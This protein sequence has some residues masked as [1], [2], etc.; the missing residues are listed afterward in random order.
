M[1]GLRGGEVSYR[2]M[3]LFELAVFESMGVFELGPVVVD[4]GMRI[5][6]F[7]DGEP[8]TLSQVSVNAV[9]DEAGVLF[10]RLESEVE[11]LIQEIGENHSDAIAQLQRV[12]AFQ[13]L[14]YLDRPTTTWRWLI[15]IDKI[16]DEGRG[17]VLHRSL[18][19]GYRKNLPLLRCIVGNPFRPVAFDPAWRSETAVSLASS[20]YEERAF[21]RMPILADALEEAGCD[22]ADVLAHCR[23][24]GPHA[25]GCWVID[26]VLSKQ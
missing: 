6:A 25:R 2:K 15:P 20:I 10:R 16:C 21:D 18:L 9:T 5:T 24:P 1:C 13:R 14:L 3:L 22:H 17:G 4:E 11:S 7:G 19:N 8:S 12:A 26:G 23:G